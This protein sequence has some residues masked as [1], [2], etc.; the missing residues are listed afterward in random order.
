[1]STKPPERK[2]QQRSLLTQQKLIDAAI[3]AFAENGYKGTS[4]RDIA[5]RA[6]VHHPLI[7]YHF[8]NKEQ[9]WHAAA[10]RVWTAF[11]AELT[12]ALAAERSDSPRREMATVVGTYVR[13]AQRQPALH[14]LMAQEANAPNK[15][16]EWLAETHLKPFHELLFARV[17][18]LQ[19]AGIA[20]PGDPALIA[21]ALRVAAGSLLA[22]TLE[23]RVTSGLDLDTEEAAEALTALLMRLFF[24]G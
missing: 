10:D 18:T 2:Q 22:L 23:V 16:L 5:D 15:R 1:M 7:T 9:L 24:P 21:N 20:P 14:K 11:R 13:Y 12:A 17:R 8:K 6:G 19:G 4:T 3:E